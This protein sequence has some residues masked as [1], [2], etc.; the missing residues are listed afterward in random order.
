VDALEADLGAGH[1]YRSAREERSAS[2]GFSNPGDRL[3]VAAGEWRRP[4]G[5][6]A[7]GL[8]KIL[9]GDAWRSARPIYTQE[10]QAGKFRDIRNSSK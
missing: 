2:N 10:N 7:E 4:A 8:S 5:P 9:E 6:A 3:A 1:V